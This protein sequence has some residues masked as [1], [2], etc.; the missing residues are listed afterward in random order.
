MYFIYLTSSQLD[1]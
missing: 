1:F